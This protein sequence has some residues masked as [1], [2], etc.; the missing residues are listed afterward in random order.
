MRSVVIAGYK[1]SEMD[2]IHNPYGHVEFTIPRFDE[3]MRRHRVDSG[4]SRLS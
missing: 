2:P 1:S 3:F 4:T